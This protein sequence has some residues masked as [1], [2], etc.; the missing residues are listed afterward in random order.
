MHQYDLFIGSVSEQKLLDVRLY[1]EITISFDS[2]G[3]GG[4]AYFMG[5]VTELAKH[6]RFLKHIT[7]I[8]GVSAGAYAGFFLATQQTKKAIPFWQ[9]V[10]SPVRVLQSK[11]MQKNITILTHELFKETTIN[12]TTPYRVFAKLMPSTSPTELRPTLYDRISS[13]FGFKAK[14][15]IYWILGIARHDYTFCVNTKKLSRTKKNTTIKQE[16]LK[17]TLIGGARFLPILMGPTIKISSS[18]AKVVGE[19]NGGI[20]HDYGMITLLGGLENILPEYKKK[21]CLHIVIVGQNSSESFWNSL[22]RTKIKKC[23]R[24]SNNVVILLPTIRPLP[25]GIF[26]LPN[27]LSSNRHVL[28]ESNT[29]GIQTAKNFVTQFIF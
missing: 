10:C 24:N 25:R 13:R 1:D 12:F 7:L 27:W 22:R 2:G 26:G 6:K 17:K 4:G 19:E 11:S 20:I 16:L 18:E 5:F 14:E 28:D 15:F 21:K 3:S 29:I 9:Q 23:I 8:T